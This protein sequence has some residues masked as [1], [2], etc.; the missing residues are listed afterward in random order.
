MNTS[1][2]FKLPLQVQSVYT[3]CRMPMMNTEA[4]A[5]RRQQAA[6]CARRGCAHSPRLLAGKAA[7][8]GR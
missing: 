8:G 3:D 2:I 1:Q 6:G 5:R 4:Q 7:A